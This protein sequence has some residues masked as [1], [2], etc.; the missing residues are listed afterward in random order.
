MYTPQ[1]IAV[2]LESWDTPMMCLQHESNVY[3][4][5]EGGVGFPTAR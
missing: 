4:I 2:K 5:L 3:K 1:E